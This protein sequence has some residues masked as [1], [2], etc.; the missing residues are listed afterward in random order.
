M[1]L[2]QTSLPAD[3]AA[4][5]AAT[6]AS[7]PPSGPAFHRTLN[8]VLARH[9][10]FFGADTLRTLGDRRGV[11]LTA[12]EPT[13]TPYADRW[14]A[15]FLWPSHGHFQVQ[16]FENLGPNDETLFFSPDEIVWSADHL[17]LCGISLARG[18]AVCPAIRTYRLKDG[19]WRLERSWQDGEEE[20]LQDSCQRSTGLRFRRVSGRPDPSDVLFYG[21]QAP[22]L[23]EVAHAGPWLIDT[24]EWRVTGSKTEFRRKRLPT[25]LASLEDLLSARREGQGRRFASLVDHPLA[26][27]AWRIL[28]EC[29]T[30]PEVD[31]DEEGTSL[32]V[33][34]RWVFHFR[35][36]KGIYRL[37][38][39]E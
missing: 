7:A 29:G 13:E 11:F 20:P 28:G 19:R 30:K 1:I 32:R 18:S 31:G 26:S 38:S 23:M 21:R 39:I 3:L 10:A 22:A 2:P 15:F 17:T 5:L 9:R 36:Q 35:R 24:V 27:R 33:D 37:A 25:A 6:L 12:E 34:T 16:T 8:G 4:D 14:E